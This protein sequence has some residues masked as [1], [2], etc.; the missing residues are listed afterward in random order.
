MADGQRHARRRPQPLILVFGHRLLDPA[1]DAAAHT[2]RAR[3]DVLGSLADLRG[4]LEVVLR[5]L[6]GKDILHTSADALEAFG[7][8]LAPALDAVLTAV[9][10]LGHGLFR[11]AR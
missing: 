4:V 7:D 10:G 5:A 3:A 11:G 2:G 9:D 8:L 6:A 1:A